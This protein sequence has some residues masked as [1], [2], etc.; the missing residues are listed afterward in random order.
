MLV[1]LRSQL[2]QSCFKLWFADDFKLEYFRR[3]EEVLWRRVYH[4][5]Y[6]LYKSNRGLLNERELM[7]VE[8]HIFSGI[9]MYSG[10][11]VRLR[12][13]YGIK[14]TRK[15]LLPLGLSLESLDDSI[16][17]KSE[18]DSNSKEKEMEEPAVEV[19]SRLDWAHQAIY[20]CLVYMGDLY[21]YL[22][23]TNRP[24]C[25]PLAIEMYKSTSLYDPHHGM[26]F[27]QLATMSAND[28]Y[29]LD[30]ICNYMRCCSRAKPFEGAAG[31]MKKIFDINEKSFD[32]LNRKSPTKVLDEC[33]KRRKDSL[34]GS[35]TLMRRLIVTFIKLV[36][37]L[38][39]S[40]G[41]IVDDA[42]FQ[43]HQKS[44]ASE[45][46]LFF[47]ILKEAM[48]LPKP[49]LSQSGEIFQETLITFAGGSGV[50]EKPVFVS[51]TIMYEFANISLMLLARCQNSIKASDLK[52]CMIY[53]TSVALTLN[54]FH[55]ITTRCH[56]T[57]S[58][59][60]DQLLGTKAPNSHLTKMNGQNLLDHLKA[61]LAGSK[62]NILLRH[63][64]YENQSF[65]STPNLSP[66][67]ALSRLR[68]REA[69]V[70]Y[71]DGPRMDN[72][73]CDD[74]DMSEL[75]ETALSTIDALEI[76]SDMS[77][78]EHHIGNKAQNLIDLDS[79][80]DEQTLLVLDHNE[81]NNGCSPQFQDPSIVIAHLSSNSSKPTYPSI[82]T[83]N[84]RDAHST[85]V[86]DLLT[87]DFIPTSNSI[88]SNNKSSRPLD[89]RNSI[90]SLSSLSPIDS[91]GTLCAR[92]YGDEHNHNS[93]Q[94]NMSTISFT[95]IME[96]TYNETYLPSIKIFCDW[97]LSNSSLI[98]I[99]C[100]SFRAFF[101]ELDTLVTSL[102]KLE[103]YAN[104]LRSMDVMNRVANSREDS[105]TVKS[106]A[107]LDHK[108]HGPSW[109]QKYPLSVDLPLMKLKSLEVVH[110]LN[111]NYDSTVEL[112]QAEMGYI[113]IQCILAFSDV[114]AVCFSPKDSGS[115]SA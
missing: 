66:R 89:Q 88:M 94:G 76:S 91:T 62:E 12:L 54:L 115:T 65:N 104:S 45:I 80:G 57:I 23:E 1:D 96:F 93:H 78:A 55:Y 29:A 87:G 36:S 86:P 15:L 107:V 7:L 38:W 74:S 17:L 10:L 112:S 111:I 47:V 68:Q 8:A 18:T 63:G 24:E 27:N 39:Q 60:M 83:K 37:D 108:Y 64:S 30:A 92:E 90:P 114:V 84:R 77:D 109:T 32:E 40:V 44:I 99:N 6:K 5:I 85:P 49:Q 95:K 105:Q 51:T 98:S 31:N 106:S 19:S 34:R 110:K 81:E 25:R 56:Q 73:D 20:R 69:A 43:L 75:E 3:A 71:A 50:V 100:E 35:T 4:D 14:K 70:N 13:H 16:K 72:F 28:N 101:N 102:K 52:A 22:I 113:C 21:R 46:K 9:G 97:L 2:C 33:C 41:K 79:S 58:S 48:E 59:K 42:T 11:I 53:E 67:R 82:T 26:P 61:R 103:G